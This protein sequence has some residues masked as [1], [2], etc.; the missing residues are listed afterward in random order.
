MNSY[1]VDNPPVIISETWITNYSDEFVGWG[2]RIALFKN[3]IL[4][5]WTSYPDKY[6]PNGTHFALFDFNGNILAAEETLEEATLYPTQSMK[7]NYD[8][9]SLIWI[10]PGEG[11]MLKVNMLTEE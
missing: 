3:S 9:K 1:N 2:S 10:S 8:G 11:N 5:A 6:T 7:K 4:V